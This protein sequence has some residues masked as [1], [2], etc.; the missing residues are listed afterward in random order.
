MLVSAAVGIVAW[1]TK[2]GA[3]SAPSGDADL[4]AKIVATQ[5]AMVRE[6]MVIELGERGPKVVP[7]IV[8]AYQK[9]QDS[10]LRLHLASAL[11][12]TQSPE[13]RAAM[14]KLESLVRWTNR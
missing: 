10:G 13:A 4:L 1:R 12:R 7:L 14:E 9:A 6:D 5:D 11:Y 3:A 2:Q 8:D